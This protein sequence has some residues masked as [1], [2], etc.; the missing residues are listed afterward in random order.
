MPEHPRAVPV[1]WPALGV[2]VCILAALVDLLGKPVAEASAL[3]IPTA[4]YGRPYAQTAIKVT[5]SSIEVV[6]E[7]HWKRFNPAS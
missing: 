4:G 7:G 2:R 1:S 3:C 5:G 6:S